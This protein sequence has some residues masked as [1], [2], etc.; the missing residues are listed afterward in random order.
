MTIIEKPKD[1]REAADI[2]LML[3]DRNL[4]AF[5]RNN[6]V[7]QMAKFGAD[8][9]R[10]ANGNTEEATQMLG[11]MMTMG[12]LAASHLD[13]L[14][15]WSRKEMLDLLCRKQHDYGH[16]NI[17]GFGMIGVAVRMNDKIARLENLT[18]LD[19]DAA[20]ESL[21]DTWTDI[22]GYAVIAGMLL[23][24]TFELELP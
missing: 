20:N 11:T 5:G 14:G 8:M 18:T 19:T 22:V 21:I 4:R 9:R 3:I 16:G 23:V 10:L 13:S 24:N 6:P 17:L 2:E 15:L 7:A 12:T 1:W